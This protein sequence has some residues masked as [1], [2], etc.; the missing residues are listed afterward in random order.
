MKKPV[1]ENH[2]NE[3]TNTTREKH[4]QDSAWGRDTA[5]TPRIWSNILHVDDFQKTHVEHLI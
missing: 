4:H 1:S 5:T 2:F 3:A